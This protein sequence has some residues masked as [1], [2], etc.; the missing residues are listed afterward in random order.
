MSKKDRAVFMND[1]A[2]P[3]THTNIP[4]IIDKHYHKFNYAYDIVDELES[5]TV[6]RKQ[7]KSI[8][9]EDIDSCI[10]IAINIKKSG[11]MDKIVEVIEEYVEANN[12][13]VS[14]NV[15]VMSA[16]KLNISINTNF[17]EEDMYDDNGLDTNKEVH[18]GKSS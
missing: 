12:G 15:E 16:D 4:K 6:I 2:K 1:L 8:E 14:A 3:D 13:D 10:T 18:S 9:T 7:I 17:I 11:D 5:N